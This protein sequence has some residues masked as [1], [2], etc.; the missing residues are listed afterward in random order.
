M[1]A[2]AAC[3][4][5]LDLANEHA[6]A[7]TVHSVFDHAVNVD[8]EGRDALIGL[9]A[10]GSALPP[11]ALSVRTEIPFSKTNVRTGMAA[12]IRDGKFSIPEAD[13]EIDMSI[14]EPVDLSVDAVGIRY[15]GPAKTVLEHMILSAL[16]GADAQEGLSPLVT[17]AEGNAFS[18]FL[19]PRLEQL[20]AAVSTGSSDLAVYAAGRSAG[21][22]LG[23]TPSSDDLL[24]G[25]LTTLHLLFRALGREHLRGMIPL[26]A[27]AAA[28]KTNRISAAF[29]LY[30]GEGL[31]NS[32]L[33]DLFRSVFQFQD[34]AAAVRAI[35][36]VLAI[37][38][39]SGAD[40]LTGV[41][42]AL[43]QYNGGN[44]HW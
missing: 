23:L 42:L 5:L 13:L 15:R 10:R 32:A 40:I 30:S 26:M 41:A 35:E 43:R 31:C 38:S 9:V 34:E 37:G 2:I 18:K 44:E 36:R 33:F 27:Q 4:R 21:C 28:K 11:Y 25:Y 12:A 16:N 3:K 6:L 20:F 24:T 14:A 29:L 8:L 1:I 22:G 17:D 39:T 19:K 7:G